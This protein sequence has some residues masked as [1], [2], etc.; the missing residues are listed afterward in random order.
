MLDHLFKAR[1]LAAMAVK[2]IRMASKI[3]CLEQW[4][5]A[6]RIEFVDDESSRVHYDLMVTDFEGNIC[7]EG[8]PCFLDAGSARVC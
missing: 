2:N 7:Y 6:R 5:I 3:R 1:G 4:E 8:K